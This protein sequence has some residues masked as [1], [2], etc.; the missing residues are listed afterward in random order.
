MEKTPHLW[1]LEQRWGAYIENNRLQ[2]N[3]N[4]P[5]KTHNEKD[6]PFL[7]KLL[8]PRTVDTDVQ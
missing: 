4:S 2:V 3:M 5:D 8:V 6:G 1:P 7:S